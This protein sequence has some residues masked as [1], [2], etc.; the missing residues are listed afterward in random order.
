[1]PAAIAFFRGAARLRFRP[2]NGCLFR[3]DF[4]E[5]IG[6]PQP[7]HTLSDRLKNAA[8]CAL[9]SAEF[10]GETQGSAITLI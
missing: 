9:E 5:K 6:L 2:W 3:P 10:R 7:R 1:M 8:F 4:K